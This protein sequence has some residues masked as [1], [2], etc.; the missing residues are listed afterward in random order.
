M[1]LAPL[2]GRVTKLWPEAIAHLNARLTDCRRLRAGRALLPLLLPLALLAYWIVAKAVLFQRLEYT[3]DMFAF[4]QISRSFADGRPLLYDNGWGNERAI[5]NYYIV[6]L[7]YPLTALLSAYGLFVGLAGLWLLALL[8][9]RRLAV[10]ADRWKQQLYQIIIFALVLGPVSFYLWDDEVYGWHAQLC[11][12]PLSILFVVYLVRGSR[13]VWVPAALLV[14]THEAGAVLAWALHVLCAAT[15]SARTG[16]WRRLLMITIGW[17]LVF[18]T[19]MG[20]LAAMQHHANDSRLT[21]ALLN[22]QLAAR[23]GSLAGVVLQMGWEVT[24]LLLAGT[25]VHLAGIPARALWVASLCTLPLFVVAVISDLAA[26]I[27]TDYGPVWPPRMVMFWA[28]LIAECL[29]AIHYAKPTAPA[30]TPLRKRG[31]V[32]L[33]VAIVAQVLA[34]AVAARYNFV[35]RF[36]AVWPRRHLVA[37]T[38]TPREDAFLRCLGGVLPHTT[39]VASTVGLFARFHRQYVVWPDRLTNAWTPPELLVCDETDRLPYDYGCRRLLWNV[40]AAGSAEALLVDGLAAAYVPG[41][42][43]LVLGCR[44]ALEQA[45]V[46]QA[47]KAA[48]AWLKLLDDGSYRESWNQAGSLAKD[49]VS[50]GQW[51]ETVSGARRPLGRLISRKLRLSSY[52]TNLPGAPDGHYVVIQYNSAFEN[53]K[54]GDETVKAVL[55]KD[56]QWRP[57]GYSIDTA[58]VEAFLRRRHFNP[59]R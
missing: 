36:A 20:L 25:V 52:A 50:E 54:S 53:K 44:G 57:I 21:Q 12:L 14:L 26:G 43:G 17:L 16:K 51:E 47:T 24:L 10:D 18:G 4:L 38:L 56:G 23:N 27:L 19:G 46:E 55:E 15:G 59:S 29:L 9:I 30:L 45:A 6:P 34:L 11:F 13:W 28:L 31:S 37:D 32:T 22:E 8:A 42:R 40:S 41:V 5:H 58:F 33:A 3:A 39:A 48:D 2:R 35:A 7:F 49:R 1:A